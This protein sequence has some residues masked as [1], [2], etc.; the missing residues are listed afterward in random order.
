MSAATF[1][2]CDLTDCPGWL[3][4]L[5]SASYVVPQLPNVGI[6]EIPSL[7]HRHKRV[8]LFGRNL[9][10]PTNFDLQSLLP[11]QHLAQISPHATLELSRQPIEVLPQLGPTSDMSLSL[12]TSL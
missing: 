3:H 11:P 8:L 2:A 12:N 10:F 7:N 5:N 9:T 6:K 4:F 1:L